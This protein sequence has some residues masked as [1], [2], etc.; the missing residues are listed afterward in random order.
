MPE[1]PVYGTTLRERSKSL[2][3]FRKWALAIIATFIGSRYLFLEI[4]KAQNSLFDILTIGHLL[5]LF[6][7]LILV[8]LWIWATQKELDLCFYWLDPYRYIPPSNLTETIMIL[9][10]SILLCLLFWASSDPLFYS[11]IFTLYSIII[12]FTNRYAL[13]EV[14]T[15]INSSRTRLAKELNDPE[16]RNIIQEY[17][18]GV[19]ILDTYFIQRP[20]MKRF[21]I[22]D[23]ASL[24]ALGLGIAWLITKIKLIGAL[25]YLV[26]FIII[27]VSEIVMANWR[28]IRDNQLRPIEAEIYECKRS[29]N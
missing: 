11:I 22:I 20:W 27:L 8:F 25:T 23:I 3:A 12:T 19:N 9:G 28:I 6:M 24:L 7:T 1:H 4:D 2:I 5:V 10:E 18:K 14:R 21:I 15:A 29:L 17:E 13:S 16:K 26:I